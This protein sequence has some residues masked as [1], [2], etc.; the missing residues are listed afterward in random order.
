MAN[1][2]LLKRLQQ[3]TLSAICVLLVVEYRIYRDLESSLFLGSFNSDFSAADHG[4]AAIDGE[5]SSFSTL[6]PPDDHVIRVPSIPIDC[7]RVLL[8][9]TELS[10]VSRKLI[11]RKS[12]VLY[13]QPSIRLVHFSTY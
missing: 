11:D 1:M 8:I 4:I 9:P 10:A 7:S 2:V 6:F 13:L 12:R 5:D 3:L